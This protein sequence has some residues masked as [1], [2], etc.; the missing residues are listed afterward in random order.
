MVQ[1][2]G[3]DP[4]YAGSIPARH[5]NNILH[6]ALLAKLNK[7]LGYELRDWGFESL[8][9]YQHTIA[10]SV[11][12]RGGDNLVNNSTIIGFVAQR[13]STGLLTRVSRFQN[14]PGPP[15]YCERGRMAYAA[16]CKTA[17]TGSIPVVHSK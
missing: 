12:S 17:Y 11:W 6:N 10:R 14:S 8:G 4:V 2:T 16:A 7:A 3:C 1:R 13:Q 5:P 9:G 15:K